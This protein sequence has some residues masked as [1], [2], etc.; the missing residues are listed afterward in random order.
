MPAHPG[1]QPAVRIPLGAYTFGTEQLDGCLS[2]RPAHPWPGGRRRDPN[3]ASGHGR[4]NLRPGASDPDRAGTP[5][6]VACHCGAGPRLEPGVDPEPDLVFRPTLI[7]GSFPPQSL[8]GEFKRPAA[9]AAAATHKAPADA[10]I[11]AHVGQAYGEF[12]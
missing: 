5:R 9:E 6:A 8:D 7:V 11:A 1:T 3:P 10:V 4:W 12:R 2:E